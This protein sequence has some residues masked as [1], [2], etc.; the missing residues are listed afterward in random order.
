MKSSVLVNFSVVGRPV[1]KQE[2]L[3]R[4]CWVHTYTGWSLLFLMTYTGED[5]ELR[6]KR[7]YITLGMKC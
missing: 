5:I 3:P 7:L 2:G 1:C 6:L 4:I